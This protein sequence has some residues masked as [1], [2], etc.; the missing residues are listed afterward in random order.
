MTP[1]SV[2]SS[3]CRCEAAKLPKP[4]LDVQ[5]T[6]PFPWYERLKF[7]VQA[8][9]LLR[10]VQM[11]RYENRGSMPDGATYAGRTFVIGIRGDW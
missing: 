11:N 10:Q 1:V 9:N 5:V 4:T 6:F 3:S 7:T 2:R 8:Q